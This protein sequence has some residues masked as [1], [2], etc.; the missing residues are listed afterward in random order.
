MRRSTCGFVWAGW[1]AAGGRPGGPYDRG[2]NR[3][4][5]GKHDDKG[6]GKIDNKGKFT[7]QGN[8]SVGVDMAHGHGGTSTAEAIDP[9]P[10]R[11]GE[12]IRLRFEQVTDLVEEQYT[13]YTRHLLDPPQGYSDPEGEMMAEEGEEEEL[14]EEE[15]EEELEEVE[16]EEEPVA[17][18]ADGDPGDGDHDGHGNGRAEGSVSAFPIFPLSAIGTRP[19]SASAAGKGGMH[20]IIDGERGKGGAVPVLIHTQTRSVP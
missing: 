11:E 16:V 6:K 5:N 12:A 1:N 10:F 4:G 20:V 3:K 8:G 18:D 15:V 2:R 17:D 13:M 14:V 9:Y 7:G 19:K